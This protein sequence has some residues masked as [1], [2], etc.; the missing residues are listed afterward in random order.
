MSTATARRPEPTEHASYY[1]RYISLVPETDVA[2]ASAQQLEETLTLLR[3]IPESL[4]WHRYSPEKWTI[5]QVIGHMLD[6]ER[7]MCY[8]AL[9]FARN[10]QVALPGFDQD[11]FNAA[12]NFDEYDLKTLVDEYE[13]TRRANLS[14]LK[15]LSPEAW[16]RSGTASEN[17]VTVRAL[18]YIMVGHERY[19]L[20]ILRNR[21]LANQ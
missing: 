14:F 19:H 3:S 10:G 4:G 13:A 15:H 12:A 8:R 7:V 21:Y 11:E 9:T 18:A 5:K 2:A 6:T 17:P 1:E 16:S 20:E